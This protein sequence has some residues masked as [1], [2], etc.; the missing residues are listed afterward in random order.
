M[1]TILWSLE[2]AGLPLWATAS[3]IQLGA[4]PEDD[5]GEPIHVKHASLQSQIRQQDY[6]AVTFTLESH[7]RAARLRMYPPSLRSNHQRSLPSLSR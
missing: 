5:L 7:L 1:P 6:E 4:C 3:A 2:S